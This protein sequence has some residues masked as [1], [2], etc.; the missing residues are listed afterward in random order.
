[1]YP[2]WINISED[3][4]TNTGVPT[5]LDISIENSFRNSNY[6][7][8]EIKFTSSNGQVKKVKVVYSQVPIMVSEMKVSKDTFSFN[9]TKNVS[10]FKIYNNGDTLYNWNITSTKNYIS[11]SPL[12]GA[13]N[14]GDSI[15][16]N[17]NYD[18]SKVLTSTVFELDSSTLQNN[19]GDKIFLKHSIDN[20]IDAKYN[21]S[22]QITDAIFNKVTNEIIAIDNFNNQLHKINP[23][24]KNINSINLPISPNCI[25]YNNNDKVAIGAN[26]KVLIYS[27]ASMTLETT[28]TI[29]KDA[30]DIIYA[31]NNWIYVTPNKDQHENVLCI[32]PSNWI[33]TSHTGNSIYEGSYAVAHPS[34]PR[35][36]VCDSRVSPI[37][38]DR[39]G[40]SNGTAVNDGDSPYHG[41]HPM[42]GELFI[43]EDGKFLLSGSGRIFSSNDNFSNDMLY[44]GTLSNAGSSWSAIFS[45]ITHNMATKKIYGSLIEN[46][47]SSS[48]PKFT[49]KVYQY[50]D[51]FYTALKSYDLSSYLTTSSGSPKM[52]KPY[53]IKLFPNNDGSKLIVCS[54]SAAT[55]IAKYAIEII[56]L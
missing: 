48:E 49:S 10:S 47:N 18:K 16:I 12:S 28:V 1:M 7:E 4:G 34:K 38:I 42:S 24:T 3:N 13:L 20:F 15:T 32:N 31:S 23:F 22:I 5:I 46:G 37:D 33:V 14:K 30:F 56:D 40:I 2:S 52:V 55:G 53:A 8:G 26:G 45:N 54:K 6:L 50:S 44:S 17:I 19:F 43:T 25:A 9:N 11:F 29:S 35:F 39:M 27:I 51:D 36:Y 41:D 21:L